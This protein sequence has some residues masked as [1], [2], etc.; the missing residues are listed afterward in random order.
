M[1]LYIYICKYIYI[2]IHI[3]MT[4]WLYIHFLMFD[5]QILISTP[6]DTPRLPLRRRQ[7]SVQGDPR[8]QVL[9]QAPRIFQENTARNSASQLIWL[10]VEPH[11]WNVLVNLDDDIP[12]WMENKQCSKLPTSDKMMRYHGHLNKNKNILMFDNHSYS[13]V[14]L[15][16]DN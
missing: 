5:G 9:R 4:I 11:L 14:L 13:C 10:V 15:I 16:D 7:G 2:Y 6:G 12:N 1:Y 8:P 3:H